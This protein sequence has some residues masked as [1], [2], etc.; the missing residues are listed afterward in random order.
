MT[1][2][3]VALTTVAAFLAMGHLVGAAPTLRLPNWRPRGPSRT[4]T[5]LTQAGVR[6]TPRQYRTGSVVLGLATGGLVLAVTSVPAVCVVPAAVAASAPRIA[7]SRQRTRRLREVAAAWPDGL[8]E[9]TTSIAAGRSLSQA[10]IALA[11][12][13]P[14][15][16]RVAFARFGVLV[17][18]LGV[19][20]ALETVKAELADPT[21]DRVIEV[22]ALA[23]ERGGRTVAEVLRDLADA[24]TED[25]RTLAEIETNALEHQLNARAVFALPWLVLLMLT[26]RPGDFRE[27][28]ASGVG[29]VVVALAGVVSLLGVVIVQR[30]GRETVEPRVLV[31]R[32]GSR[33]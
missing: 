17:R 32:N 10:V 5:W 20:P 11:D 15:P 9:L 23:H 24:V 30:L 16:L 1:A 27:F 4:Q 12:E 26:A 3:V 8:R 2:V 14:A 25:L 28:Y 33:A 31:P 18:M 19:V 22:L 21:S 7:I 6:L 13:G 29:L